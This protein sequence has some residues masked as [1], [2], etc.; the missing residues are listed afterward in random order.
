L[1]K[2]FLKN[3]SACLCWNPHEPINLSVGCED[4]N[5]YTFDMRKFTEAKLIHKDHVNAVLSI[6]YAPHG[7]EF[8][9][10]GFDKTI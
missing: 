8:V 10:G 6:D 7:K 2:I 5:V 1:K 4:G 3:K 9:T